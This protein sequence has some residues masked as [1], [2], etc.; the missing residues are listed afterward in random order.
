[1]AFDIGTEQPGPYAGSR[2]F[3]APAVLER[4]QAIPTSGPE[5]RVASLMKVEREFLGVVQMEGAINAITRYVGVEARLYREKK[6]PL[7]GSDSLR[8][9]FSVQPY[10]SQWDPMFCDVALS[11]DMGYVYGGYEVALPGAAPAQ[12]EKG[13]YFRVW[14]RDGTNTWKFVAEVTSPLPPP[15]P[16]P[17]R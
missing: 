7:V 15:P 2:A 17:K 6:N 9:Y 4:K 13:F 14:K 16:P 12:V 3:H 5:E 1:V 8:A 11:G 10:M